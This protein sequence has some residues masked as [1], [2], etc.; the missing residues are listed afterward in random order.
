MLQEAAFNKI[1]NAH[2][3][4]KCSQTPILHWCHVNLI[5]QDFRHNS[6]WEGGGGGV[7]NSFLTHKLLTVYIFHTSKLLT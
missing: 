5:R 1:R 3:N 4:K 2:K 6:S 7:A